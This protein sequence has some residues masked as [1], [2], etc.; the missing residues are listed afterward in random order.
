MDI[1]LLLNIIFVAI[2]S[3]F[4]HCIGMCGGFNLIL[5]SHLA[6]TRAKALYIAL[7]HMA[8]IFAYCLLGLGF[9]FFGQ[10]IILSQ[11]A[12]GYALFITGLLMVFFGIAFLTRGKILAFIENAKISS[13]I[14]GIAIKIKTRFKALYIVLLGFLNGLIPC[15][16]VYYFLALSFSSA[17]AFKSVLIMLIFGLS[18]LPALVLFSSFI[19]A[20]NVKFKNFANILTS[21]FIGFYGLYLAFKG[22]MLL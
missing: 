17:S 3:S 15:G 8:R 7:F 21:L 14:L 19:G 22:F 4:S 11:S 5:A 18:T 12:K 16:I 1:A 6:K 10:A 20:L 2:I 9:G 13:F